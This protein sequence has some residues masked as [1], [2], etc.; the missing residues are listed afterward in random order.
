[1]PRPVL[2]ELVIPSLPMVVVAGPWKQKCG[3]TSKRTGKPCQNWALPG[4]SVCRMHGGGRRGV[5]GSLR[6]DD[7]E[8]LTPSQRA[9]RN[10]DR[11]KE[12]LAELGDQ[13]VQTVKD[14]LESDQ[15]R[16]TDRLRAAELVM[17]RFVPKKAEVEV[18]QHEAA[19][20]DA[21]IEEA[22][23][24]TLES[25]GTEGAVHPSQVPPEEEDY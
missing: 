5:G 13:A 4:G 20:L 8:Q 15:A 24:E 16:A 14:I 17:D 25:T 7:G 21:E 12:R 9:K 1:M 23:G 3:G 11:I 2:A 22:L 18:S 6:N 19:D 10:Q